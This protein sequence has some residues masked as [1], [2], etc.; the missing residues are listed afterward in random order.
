MTLVVLAEQSQEA[1]FE[2]GGGEGVGQN[3]DTVGG[4]RQGLH[5]QQADLVQTTGE[6]V[7]SVSVGC[8]TLRQAF[9]KL[10]QHKTRRST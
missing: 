5:L 10:Q 2:D 6:K 9:V 7:D 4:V 8:N 3:N 1:L